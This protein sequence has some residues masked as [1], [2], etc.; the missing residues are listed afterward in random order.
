MRQKYIGVYVR[1]EFQIMKRFNLHAVL[2]WEPLLP[3]RYV[4]GRPRPTFLGACVHRRREDREVH[5]RGPRD[6]NTMRSRA[7]RRPMP[8]AT[9]LCSSEAGR[10]IRKGQVLG[11][12]RPNLHRF[13]RSR[14]NAPAKCREDAQPLVASRK[15][16]QGGDGT[17]AGAVIS[18]SI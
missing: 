4:A 15:L 8:T 3:E 16:E 7:F 17:S 12:T 5:Q 14:G 11:I 1:D 9:G 13:C 18:V 6:S 10:M 2:R